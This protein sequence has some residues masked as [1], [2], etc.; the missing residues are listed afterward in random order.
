LPALSL[1]A[2]G[3]LCAMLISGCDIDSVGFPKILQRL[4]YD[5]PVF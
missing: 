3:S 1:I 4:L 2:A 5:A